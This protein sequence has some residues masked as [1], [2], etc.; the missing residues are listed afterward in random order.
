MR[1]R[2][3]DISRPIRLAIRVKQPETEHTVSV[4]KLQSW[5]DGGGRSPNE[6]VMKSRL[7]ELL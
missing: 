4:G 2:G 7:R 3:C 5:F 6:Q 1:I